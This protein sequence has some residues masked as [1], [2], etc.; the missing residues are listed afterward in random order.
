M[1]RSAKAV[2]R[3]R[4]VQLLPEIEAGAAHARI[5]K[6]L[7]IA[8]CGSVIKDRDTSIL[9]TGLPETMRSAV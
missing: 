4:E 9:R 7:Q 5:V 6:T 8:V 3:W 2:R 1:D